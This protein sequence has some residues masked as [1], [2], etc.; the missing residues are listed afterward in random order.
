MPCFE[1]SFWFSIFAGNFGDSTS[2][3]EDAVNRFS[4]SVDRLKP[5]GF[6]PEAV[7]P[8]HSGDALH[9]S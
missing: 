8:M 3:Y 1:L 5:P 6:T 2:A 4:E 9:L 7:L